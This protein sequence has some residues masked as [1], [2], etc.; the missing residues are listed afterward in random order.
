MSPGLSEKLSV[1]KGTAAKHVDSN[2]RETVKL[3]NW[4]LCIFLKI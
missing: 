2:F 3:L 1:Y 4:N